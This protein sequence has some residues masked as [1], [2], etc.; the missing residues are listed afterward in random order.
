MTEELNAIAAVPGITGLCLHKGNELIHHNLPAAMG[1]ATANDLCHAVAGTF[2]AYAEAARPILQTY[3]QF[4]EGGVF[5]LRT[6]SP[7]GT[8]GREFYLTFLVSD[9]NAIGE[10]LAPARAF[11]TRQTRMAA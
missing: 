9:Q 4:P 3:F 6:G 8:S 2:S 10:V 1:T 5:V 7:E 11:L